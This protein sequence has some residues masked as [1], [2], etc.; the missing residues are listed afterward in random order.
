ML[1]LGTSCARTWDCSLNPLIDIGQVEGAFMMGLG[2]YLTEKI[3]Y[4]TTTGQ[5]LTNGTWVVLAAREAT[6]SS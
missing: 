4:D 2:Y 5:L 3:I 1:L 6:R